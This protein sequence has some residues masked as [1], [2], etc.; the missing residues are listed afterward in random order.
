[1][2]SSNRHL[3]VGASATVDDVARLWATL[4]TDY[5][6]NLK[7]ELEPHHAP[8]GLAYITANI[9]DYATMGDSGDWHRSLWSTRR[10][11]S[12]LYLISHAQLFELLISAY[13]VIDEYF[14]TGVDNRPSPL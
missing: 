1:M 6:P 3:P 2:K 8:E 5:I 11:A 9:V 7:I 14:R 10:F 13:R 12:P 4:T